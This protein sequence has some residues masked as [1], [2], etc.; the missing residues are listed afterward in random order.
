MPQITPDI[1]TIAKGLGG[2]YQ[3][4][5]ATIAHGF[6]HD[7]VVDEF[8]SFAHGHTYIGHATGCAAA[9]AVSAV[10]DR[11][12]LLSNVQQM[13]GLLKDELHNA[14]AEHPLHM[15]ARIIAQ[16]QADADIDAVAFKVARQ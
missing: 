2:G 6:I 11:E 3:P 13:G 14:F 15:Q 12:D 4:I 1:V 16:P 10:I 7:A 5:A 9:L 8:G